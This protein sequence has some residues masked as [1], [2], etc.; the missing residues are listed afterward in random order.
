MRAKLKRRILVMVVA[1]TIAAAGCHQETQQQ[2]FIEAMNHGNSAQASQI[3]L[4]MDAKSREAFAHSE[5]MKPS[6]SQ[7]D[8]QKQ[9]MQHYLDKQ[10]NNPVSV[11]SGESVEQ[12]PAVH[13]GG[14]ETLPGYAGPPGPS[15][16]SG[17]A[18]TQNEPSN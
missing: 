18:P 17:P 14:L 15:T 13:L 1:S 9:V 2:K 8:I 7:E 6:L 3:W 12:A 4:H 11:E 10:G 5:G 16:E